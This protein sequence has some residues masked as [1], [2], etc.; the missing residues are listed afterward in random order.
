[1]SDELA[2][3]EFDDEV[4]YEEQSEEYDDTGTEDEE[5][6]ESGEE[7]DSD[8]DPWS[9]AQELDPNAVKK[10]WSQYTQT[11]QELKELERET[12]RQLAEVEPFK[13]LREEILADPGLVNV[14]EDYLAN[15]KPVDREV[16]SMKQELQMMKT[17][18]MTENELERLET[19]VTQNKY[20]KVER[21]EILQYAVE[22]QIPNLQVAYKDMFF[23]EL[24]ERKAREVTEGIKRS[25]GAASIP[26]K[27][28]VPTKRQTGYTKDDL[29]KM[30]DEDFVKNYG[31]ILK[32]Y[33]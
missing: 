16:A 12:K 28:K 14:I 26:R 27:G 8:E 29:A 20:P 6:E 7:V 21:E 32:S 18:M 24:R 22:N 3:M 17:Q 1:M 25:K 33:S 4:D 13:K 5:Y 31:E 30:S 9:W 15:A 2:G 19:W 10:T 11:R 23:D